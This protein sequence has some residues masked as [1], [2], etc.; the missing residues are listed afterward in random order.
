[1]IMETIMYFDIFILFLEDLLG[2]STNEAHSLF[3]LFYF[4]SFLPQLSESVNEDTGN[5]V[6][7]YKFH[8]NN[9]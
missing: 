9:V 2:N 4:L 1:M 7:E 3:I 6:G 5:N 8:E